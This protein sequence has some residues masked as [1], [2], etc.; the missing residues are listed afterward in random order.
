MYLQVPVRFLAAFHAVVSGNNYQYQYEVRF[1]LTLDIDML[2]G[3]ISA[4]GKVNLMDFAILSGE[5]MADNCDATNLWCNEA[6]VDESGDVGMEDLA[7]MVADWLKGNAWDDDNQF[8]LDLD[9]SFRSI[10]LPETPQILNDEC[11]DAIVITSDTEY[12]GSTQGATG[13]DISSCGYNDI[14]DVWYNFIPPQDGLYKIYVQST[15]SFS[16]CA[17]VYSDCAGAGS[18]LYCWDQYNSARYFEA[19]AGV[20]YLIR[21]AD[22]NSSTGDFKL[23]V[24]YY[25]PPANDE[26]SGAIPVEMDQYYQCETYGA[27]NDSTSSC[28]WDDTKDA[29]YKYTATDDGTVV[30]GIY[31]NDYSEPFYT[32]AV[33]DGCGETPDELA[34]A[35]YDGG[36]EGEPVTMLVLEDAQQGETYYI[37]VARNDSDYGKFDLYV[38][39]GPENDECTDAE[40]IAV[41]DGTSGSTIGATGSDITSCGTD[42]S[43]DVWYELTSLEDQLVLIRVSDYS[44]SEMSYTVSVFDSCGGVEQ[45][46]SE[47]S[48]GGGEMETV[49]QL[50]YE[51]S[52][53][54]TIYIRV[55]YDEN[56]MGQFDLDIE[57]IEV[58]Y[59]DECVDAEAMDGYTGG[60]TLGASGS[61][62]SSC[63]TDDTH[64]VWYTFTPDTTAE[65]CVQLSGGGEMGSFAGTLTVYDGDSCSPLPTELG[66]EQI[67]EWYAEL[68]VDLTA[69]VTYL[70]RVA[71]DDAGQGYFD[72]DIYSGGPG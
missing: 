23:V 24:I 51:L 57:Q 59:N 7:S 60:T 69:E 19:T 62:E 26:C 9:F 20:S 35:T 6:D 71:S 4:D 38:E 14:Y 39:P 1:T 32:A 12:F 11:A 47:S 29:W 50:V 21:L 55:A 58:P 45:A 43:R 31:P 65:Y 16:S 28:G 64:D 41:W 36:G 70:I 63:G 27:T 46:C 48:E 8:D 34:C 22:Y 67:G 10:A 72:L 13:T 30:F 68:Y 33:F 56:A 49:A 40:S 61:D 66:C 37:R 5:W 54:Q 17:S 53:N 15:Y 25:P 52:T 42:D 44:Y 2:A 18:E 3:D